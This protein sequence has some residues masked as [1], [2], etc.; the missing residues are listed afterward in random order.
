MEAKAKNRWL[1]I[2]IQ[3]PKEFACQVLNRDIWSHS[4]VRDLVSNNFVFYQVFKTSPAGHRL[5]GYYNVDTFPFVGIVD[6]RTGQFMIQLNTTDA[7]ICCE[8]IATFLEDHPSPSGNFTGTFDPDI[9]FLG[10]SS[11]T[12]T[13]GAQVTHEVR[14]R[15][16]D[17]SLDGK[18]VNKK[19]RIVNLFGALSTR[20]DELIEAFHEAS[21]SSNGSVEDLTWEKFIVRNETENVSEPYVTL[22]FRFANG[23]RSI[24]RFLTTARVRDVCAYVEQR[25]HYPA[26][27]RNLALGHPRRVFTQEHADCTLH[28]L[29]LN[30]QEIVDFERRGAKI[31][32]T[33]PIDK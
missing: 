26:R 20:S 15:L 18:D 27:S 29:H 28:E 13:N 32:S 33:Q 2:N 17:I 5:C 6:P 23:S 4:A 9:V 30:S 24:C 22:I 25:L 16:S 8:K 1:M 11:P 3:D 31:A 10:A 14:K 19:Q 7:V 21:S 12:S